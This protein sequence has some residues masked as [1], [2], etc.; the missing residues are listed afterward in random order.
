[1]QKIGEESY[2]YPGPPPQSKEAALVMLADSVEAAS[3]SLKVHREENLKRVIRVI[4]D[5]YLQDGQLDD[6]NFSLKELRT[7]ASSFFATLTTVYQR[8]IEYPGFD[9]EIEKKKKAE[10]NHKKDNDRSHQPP[11]EIPD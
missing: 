10:K 9:F 11:E 7:I 6:C 8:R 1:M 4:F 5:N 2:R 3:R